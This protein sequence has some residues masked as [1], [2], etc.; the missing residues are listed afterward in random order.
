MEEEFQILTRK[1]DK[2]E[3]R[4]RNGIQNGC[5]E[6]ALGFH[7][8]SYGDSRIEFMTL[9]GKPLL[10]SYFVELLAGEY[11]TKNLQADE[12]SALLI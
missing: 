9:S 3:G 2:S 8:T 12:F 10:L 5:L 1:K 11:Y 7:R 6:T 4:I